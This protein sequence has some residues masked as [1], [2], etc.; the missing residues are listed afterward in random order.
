M[1]ELADLLPDAVI[2][3]R[4]IETIFLRSLNEPRQSALDFE[5]EFVSVAINQ[6]HGRR[7]SSRAND[8]QRALTFF[9]VVRAAR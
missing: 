1:N 9:N 5:R 2:C 6:T 4:C 3:H 8:G 7:A